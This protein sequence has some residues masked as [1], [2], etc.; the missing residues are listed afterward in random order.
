MSTNITDVGCCR[1]MS[2]LTSDR[3]VHTLLSQ[4]HAEDLAAD[5]MHC[6][7][8]FKI[9]SIHVRPPETSQITISSSYTDF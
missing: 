2:N 1:L 6:L 7:A 9:G 3:T 8:L 4:I 5:S